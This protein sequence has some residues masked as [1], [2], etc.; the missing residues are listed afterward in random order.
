MVS[1]RTINEH[2][3]KDERGSTQ[4]KGTKKFLKTNAKQLI[5]IQQKLEFSTQQLPKTG[6]LCVHP[7]EK[8]TES[9]ISHEANAFFLRRM[10]Q[11]LVSIKDAGRRITLHKT[12][13]DLLDDL[14][15]LEQE[16]VFSLSHTI[17]SLPQ[18]NVIY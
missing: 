11:D 3:K 2:P 15:G 7:T 17:I 14:T 16:E 12:L 9:S 18:A 10:S 4:P 6:K 8:L 5:D 13:Q 1:Q